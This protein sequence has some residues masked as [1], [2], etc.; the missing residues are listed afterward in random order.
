[1]RSIVM[2]IFGVACL[3][4]AC[5]PRPV[6]HGYCSTPIEG[7][8]PGDTLK[9][10]VDT[11][12]ESGAYVL[13]LGLRASA[14][15]PYPYRSVWLAVRQHWH[16]PEQVRIDTIEFKLTDAKGDMMGHGVSLYQYSLPLDTLNLTAGNSVDLSINHVMRSEML[17]GIASVGVKLVRL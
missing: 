11:L 6:A 15:T 10:S 2:M 5:D 7:W 1:M 8:E 14:S 9:F 4:T 3:L 16:H 17:P 12:R 13:I